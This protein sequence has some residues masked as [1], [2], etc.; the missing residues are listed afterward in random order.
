MGLTGG[1]YVLRVTDINGCVEEE[2]FMLVHPNIISLLAN[3][4]QPTCAETKDGA[5][6]I[7]ATGGSGSGYSY[8]WSSNNSTGL[9]VNAEDQVGLS[10]GTYNVTV[11]DG[12]GCSLTDQYVL[13]QPVALESVESVSYTHLTLPTN[14]EV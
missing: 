5:I 1:T 8:V 4:T 2:T 7:T 14:R 6:S 3:T 9:N 11:T 12:S 10:G 13:T